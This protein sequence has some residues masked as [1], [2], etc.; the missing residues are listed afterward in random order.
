M[1]DP[2]RSKAI[3]G[4]PGNPVDAWRSSFKSLCDERR[5]PFAL[6]RLDNNDLKGL[7]VSLIS[8]LLLNLP[9]V[10]E[11]RSG[12]GTDVLRT[13]LIRLLSDVTSSNFEFDRIRPLLKAALADGLDDA[14]IWDQVAIAT[15]ESTPPPQ[16]IPPSIQ[17]TPWSQNTSSFVNSLELRENMDPILKLELEHQKNVG[18]P[19]FC[20]TVFSGVPDLEAVS[21]TVFRR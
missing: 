10:L 8:V 17:Q 21:A 19:H 16:P 12:S 18:L 15:A 13:D 4:N 2:S 7:T 6:D 3:Q 11:R 5:V 14:H 20:A 1:T 9:A